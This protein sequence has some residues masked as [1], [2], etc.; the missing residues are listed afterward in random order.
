MKLRVILCLIYGLQVTS[1]FAQ[2]DKDELYPSRYSSSDCNL[3]RKNIDSLI[4]VVNNLPNDTLKVILYSRLSGLYHFCKNDSALLF[5]KRAH[6]LAKE[7]KYPRGVCFGLE[8]IANYYGT[9]GTNDFEKSLQYYNEAAKIAE[10][11]NLSKELQGAFSCILNLYFYLGDFPKAMK[12]STKALMLAEKEQDFSKIAYYNNLL[13]FIYLRQGN[14]KYSKKYYQQYF[15]NAATAGDSIMMTDAK[16]GLA[17]VLLFEKKAR[18]ALPVLHEIL[19]F[20]IDQIGGSLFF[21]RDRIPYTQFALAKAYRD[22]GDN[23]QALKFCLLGFENAK[24]IQFNAYDLANYYIIIGEVYENLGQMN[25]AIKTFHLGLALSVKIKHAE[26]VRDALQALSRIYEQLKMFDSA[27]YYERQFNFMKDSITS[28]KIRREIEQINAEYNVAKKDQEIDQQ[29]RLH[30]A[31]IS[32]QNIITTSIIA[33]F[34]LALIIGALSYNRYR[35]K[36]QTAFQEELNRKQNELFNTVTT[37]QDKERK[38]IAQDIHDQVGSVLSAAKLQLSGL[39]ELKGQLSEDQKRKYSSAMTL[40]DQAAEE[41]RNISHN[42]MPATLS[43]LGLV[44]ALRG[45]FDKISE[46]SGL[47]INFNSHGFEKRA[48]EPMEISIYPIVLELINNVVKHAHAKVATIQLIKY[49]SYI[50]ISIEDDGMGFNVEMAKTNSNGIGIRN[51]ISRIE[52]LNGTL[53]IDSSEG[54]GTT[55]MIDIPINS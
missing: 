17:E 26:N 4:R 8:S 15:N 22:I 38:R 48:E 41:L 51:L 30:E 53:N 25:R 5:G 7:L 37:I 6:T 33:F 24:Q 13:G 45:L 34:L 54:K 10:E 11:N 35:L 49:P 1:V 36:Q 18:E 16:M 14:T 32:Q 31:E 55:I 50:N 20:Y 42:L 19:D 47:T 43:R 44:A 39:E 12:L 23:R 46:Y 27:F 40:M 9:F 28:V 29:Q 2:T 21:K 52:Y 3:D